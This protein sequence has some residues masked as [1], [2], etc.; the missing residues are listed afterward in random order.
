MLKAVIFDID[1]TLVDSVEW[2][3]RAWQQAFQ[4]FGKKASLE[5]VR[6]QVGRGI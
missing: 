3:A 5:D 1:G 6:K 2:H 4:K